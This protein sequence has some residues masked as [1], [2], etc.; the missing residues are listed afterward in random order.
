MFAQVIYFREDSYSTTFHIIW[1]FVETINIQENSFL[2]LRPFS[3]VHVRIIIIIPKKNLTGILPVHAN[4]VL[5]THIH[6]LFAHIGKDVVYL[7]FSI[8]FSFNHLLGGPRTYSPKIWG[9]GELLKMKEMVLL[10]ISW[11]LKEWF[12]KILWTPLYTQIW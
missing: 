4:P 9:P 10:Q 6:N 2:S 12:K 7:G 8:I 11:T 1:D 5:F 3:Q